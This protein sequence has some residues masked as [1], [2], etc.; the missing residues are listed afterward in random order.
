MCD[1]ART[2]LVFKGTS[3]VRLTDDFGKSFWA[4]NAVKRFDVF[5]HF[6]KFTKNL[7][8]MQEDN[9]KQLYITKYQKIRARV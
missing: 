5:V 3:H 2:D 4:I 9:K 7:H 1:F 6:D 8:E